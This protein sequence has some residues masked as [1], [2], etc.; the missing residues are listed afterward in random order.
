MNEDTGRVKLQRVDWLLI[1]VLF[2]LAF[3]LRVLTFGQATDV[4]T[5]TWI[6]DAHE[7]LRGH[8]LYRDIE[9]N[10]PPF[11]VLFIA[12]G[13]WRRPTSNGIPPLSRNPSHGVAGCLACGAS[14]AW[15]R[16]VGTATVTAGRLRQFGMLSRKRA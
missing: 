8:V 6:R 12:A 13:C 15:S 10:K 2:T 9:T 1:A 4:D 14:P 11:T 5:A 16:L 7:T 3:G